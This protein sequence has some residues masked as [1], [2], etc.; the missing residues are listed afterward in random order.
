[1]H[2]FTHILI[3]PEVQYKSSSLKCMGNIQERGELCSF[4][5]RATG[6]D[7]RAALSGGQKY[8]QIPLL[9][10]YRAC[11]HRQV[12]YLNALL[13]WL[14]EFATPWLFSKALPHSLYV[15]HLNLFQWLWHTRN[16]PQLSLQTFLKF[17]KVSKTFTMQQLASACSV[18]FVKQY[19]AL[20]LDPRHFQ[21]TT[22]C[23]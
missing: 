19:Q 2:K 3:H 1:M 15:T 8:R 10:N 11:R 6:A 23:Y 4:R 18:L 13:T 16:C 7:V 17:L 14:T 20:S 22:N 21:T 5:A 12:P 9:F